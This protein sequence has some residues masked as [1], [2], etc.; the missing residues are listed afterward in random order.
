MGPING[1]PAGRR[2]PPLAP[3]PPKAWHRE[4]PVL[5]T[6]LALGVVAALL[7][8]FLF[9][10]APAANAEQEVGWEVMHVHYVPSYP[11]GIGNVYIDNDWEYRQ[12]LNIS[13]R[14]MFTSISMAFGD[15]ACSGANG[16]QG[17]M[18]D[19]LDKAREA[20]RDA[21]AEAKR[22]VPPIPV[23]QVHDDVQAVFTDTI[24]AADSISDCLT[25]R[26][27]TTR[28]QEAQDDTQ[29]LMDGIVEATKH[30]QRVAGG[31]PLPGLP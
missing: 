21:L 15:A 18:L 2:P 17:G 11:R 19:G 9:V 13:V 6:I 1:G 28:C 24:Q 22:V 12:Y 29:A 23:K 31:T 20:A 10:M 8:A 16:D 14:P 27:S 3:P 30:V 7:A 25:S 5:T 26:S 4:H